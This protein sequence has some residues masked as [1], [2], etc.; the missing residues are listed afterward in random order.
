MGISVLPSY[1]Q[2]HT[3]EEIVSVVLMQSN[4]RTSP[5]GM[6]GHEASEI[7]LDARCGT[8]T[9]GLLNTANI[10]RVCKVLPLQGRVNATTGG[11]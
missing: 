3:I 7:V 5:A 9:Y 11:Q 6:F 10:Y 4:C 8:N 2:G 1:R